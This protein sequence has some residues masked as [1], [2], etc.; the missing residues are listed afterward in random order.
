MWFTE[1]VSWL[2]P[3]V[4]VVATLIGL[5]IKYDDIKKFCVTRFSN[6]DERPHYLNGERCEDES[7]SSKAEVSYLM[8]LISTPSEANGSSLNDSLL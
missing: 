1:N 4:T 5:L 8:S 7:E 3:L 2:V 6:S